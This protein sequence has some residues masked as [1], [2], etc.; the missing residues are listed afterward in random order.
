MVKKSVP[1]IFIL[2]I[3]LVTLLPAMAETSDDCKLKGDDYYREGNLDK[4]MECYNESVKLDENY[5]RGFFKVGFLY[6]E[7]GEYEKAFEYIDKALEL[8]EKGKDTSGINI[9]DIYSEK[10]Y[11][12]FSTGK[13][14]EAITY[15]DLAIESDPAWTY[16]ILGK[17]YSLYKLDK[18]DQACKCLDEILKMEPD[19]QDALNLKQKIEEHNCPSGG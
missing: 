6:S 9:G 10:G 2:L 3:C 4:A 15:Y 14:E 8:V 1:I 19:N 17:A 18:F 11:I 13:Y 5:A 16:P 7:Y 12:L